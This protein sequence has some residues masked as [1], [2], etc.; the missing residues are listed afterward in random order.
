MNCMISSCII[1]CDLAAD[2]QR[3]TDL[4]NMAFSG[5]YDE[6]TIYEMA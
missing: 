6:A 4:Q 1:F 5:V 2:R 3:F